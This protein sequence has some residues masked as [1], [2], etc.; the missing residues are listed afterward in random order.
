MAKQSLNIGTTAND[1]TGDTLR[2]G[3]DKINDNFDELYTA[4][5]NNASLSISL[6]NPATGQVLKYNGSSFVA[7][8]FNAL[9]SALDVSGNSI[10]SSSN[11]NITLA[12]NGTGD[13]VITAGSQTTTFD[14]ATG[15]VGFG[16]T[17]SYKN[18][19][20]AL[21]NAP[22]A[23]TFPGYFY[24]VDGDDNPYVN[25][26]ITGG[27]VGDT[28]AKLLTEYSSIDDLSD[29]DITTSAPTSNQVLKWNGTKFVPADD[30]AGAGQQNIFASVAGDTGTTTANSV[31]DT[32]TIAGGT[33]IVTSVSGDT[34]TVAFNGTLTTTFA[35]LTDTDVPSITQGDSLYW[36]GSDWVVTR[37]PMTWWEVG[38]NGANHFTING[39]GF[40]S[41]TDDPTLYVIRGMTYAFDN[42][43]N[44]TNHPFRIQSTAGL[45]GTPYTT[46]QSGSGTSVLYWT[47]PMDAPNTLYYQC[48]IHALMNGT[49]NVLI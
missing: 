10:I 3:G 43:A 47:V 48:T 34:V 19:Y 40:S 5:G 15:G 33:D 39:P 42:T 9:T 26:N 32:L 25:I 21:G 30:A 20:T 37:S 44:G 35:A 27:G 8:N 13:V 41:P 6:A 38:A 1:N 7:A 4:L 2:S 46:G 36:N 29:V 12:P 31:T 22:A 14:G 45:S 18:E 11:G 28:R 49:I 24:T 23:A 16:S 17:I